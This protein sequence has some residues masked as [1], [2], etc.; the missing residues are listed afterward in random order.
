MASR[1]ANQSI[2]FLLSMACVALFLFPQ[3]VH[4]L[5]L[6]GVGN[7][8]NSVVGGV[9]VEADQSGARQ[10]RCRR[11]QSFRTASDFAQRP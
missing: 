7:N 9:T 5:Q 11:V 6:G 3:S 4:A 1:Y 8:F 2:K 10:R